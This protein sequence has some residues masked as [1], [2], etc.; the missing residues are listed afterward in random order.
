MGNK[1]HPSLGGTIMKRER[2]DTMSMYDLMAAQ[3]VTK[4]Y[5]NYTTECVA[6]VI[7][8]LPEEHKMT[9]LDAKCDL[10]Y[11]QG[12]RD[13]F[14]ELFSI[15]DNQEQTISNLIDDRSDEMHQQSED[16][17]VMARENEL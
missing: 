8:Q 11:N 13:A 14:M 17:K 15:L 10:S 2:T 6:Q 4:Q 3:T 12:K 16:E 9:S 5:L 1:A 7:A